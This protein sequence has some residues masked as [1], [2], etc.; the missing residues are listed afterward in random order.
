MTPAFCSWR[1]HLLLLPAR[2]R[3]FAHFAPRAL[4]SPPRLP[5]LEIEQRLMLLSFDKKKKR[6]AREIF[7]RAAGMYARSVHA[8]TL[9]LAPISTYYSVYNFSR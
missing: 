6:G 7:S 5:L 3:A 8:A 1:T 9:L 4:I 2:Y